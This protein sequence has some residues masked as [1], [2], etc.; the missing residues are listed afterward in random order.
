MKAACMIWVINRLKTVMQAKKL[1]Q[2]SNRVSRHHRI[3]AI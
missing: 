3:Q 1:L 2:M